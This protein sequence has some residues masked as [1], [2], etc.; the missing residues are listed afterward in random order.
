MSDGTRAPSGRVGRFLA[1]HAQFSWAQV[2][3]GA[4]IVI[5]LGGMLTGASPTSATV[6]T[7]AMPTTAPHAAPVAIVPAPAAPAAAFAPV[8]AASQAPGLTL[9]ITASPSKICAFDSD[10][11]PA[12]NALSRVTL[13]ANAGS[14]GVLAWPAVQVA[15]VIETTLYDGVYDP[16]AGDP[17]ADPCASSQQIACEESNG[18]PFFV[19][20]GA[21]IASEIQSAN[22][23]SK[24]SFALVDYFATL[25]DHDDGD[26]SEYHV[27]IADFVP[28]GSFGSAV[29]ST[30]QAQVLAGGWIYSDSD[31]SDNILDTSSITAMYG[32]IIGSGLT[33]SNATHHVIVWMGSSAPRD[34]SYTV[35]YSVSSSDERSF[36]P[37]TSATCEPSYNFAI[38]ASPDCEGWVHSQDGNVTHSIAE[39]AKTAPSCTD[40][41]GG[42]CT[43]DTID[44]WTT[45]TDYY[46]KG[47][48]T[49]VHGGGPG[50]SIVIKDVN[51]IIASGCDLAAATGG[52]WD[53]PAGLSC[54]NGDEGTLE[55]VAH[56]SPDKPN[57]NNPTL[58]AALK[59]IGFGPLVQ[60]QVAA[61]T[62][63]PLF[64][65]IPIG[66]IVLPPFGQIQSTAAC[67]HDAA[68]TRTCQTNASVLHSGGLTY[69]GWNWS[70]NH[71]NNVMYVGDSWTASFNV[72]ANGQPYA[73]VPVDACVTVECR[74]GGSG[75]VNG[76]YT[77]VT[78]VPYTNNT[79]VT[80]SFPLGQVTVQAAP[81]VALTS[82]TPPPPPPVP[83]GFPI[84]T[85]N[86]LPVIQQLGIGNQVGVAQ[87]SLQATAAGFLGAGFIRVATKNRPIANVN[88]RAGATKNFRSKFEGG[89]DTQGRPGVGRFI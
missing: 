19:K 70:T 83:P 10:T 42:V 8:P 39:L 14:G 28:A 82:S 55:Y 58:L 53:G 66:N 73:L 9:G 31:F 85:A 27:D 46:S 17:G 20:N 67:Y 26:G 47:W 2:V 40:S 57:T 62:N 72:M 79:V 59:G 4:L 37:Y 13:T 61:G 21:L 71:S 49:G 74:S 65:Y 24:V 36:S 50:G 51:A 1:R 43:V 34:P 11:C 88:V 41:I 56:G 23:H 64:T 32:T 52:T 18:V 86:P 7:V 76:L 78:Y 81:P 33:W 38:G 5:T 22:P 6:H 69:L 3:L 68:P 54:P 45:P 30:F 60:T 15:F 29:T 16:G 80:A 87:V 12:G 77:A 48:P 63:K 44:Y 35:D 75:S 25:T 89:P 84:V